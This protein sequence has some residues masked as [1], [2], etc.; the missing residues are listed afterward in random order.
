MHEQLILQD[1][2]ASHC[3]HCNELSFQLSET[4]HSFSVKLL[5]IDRHPAGA[6]RGSDQ[7]RVQGRLKSCMSGLLYITSSSS[8]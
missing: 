7:E 8:I 1:Q 3:I 6:I 2:S 5:D 4:A